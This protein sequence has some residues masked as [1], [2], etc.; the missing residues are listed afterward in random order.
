MMM[1]LMDLKGLYGDYS[2]FVGS[3]IYHCSG[4]LLIWYQNDKRASFSSASYC[5]FLVNRKLVDT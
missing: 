4:L 5:D 1:L 3:Y 2:V